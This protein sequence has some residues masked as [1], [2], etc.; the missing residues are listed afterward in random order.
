MTIVLCT[1][2]YPGNYKKNFKISNIKKIKLF[3]KEYIYHAGTKEDKD[4]I[5]SNGGRVLNITA[6]G[7][8]FMQIRKKI[9]D[10]IKKINWKK[11]FYRKD[12][13]WKVIK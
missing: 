13:G 2:G 10:I 4:E 7:N 12:I 8:N 3:K 9:I 6:V 11:G 1:K 5:L